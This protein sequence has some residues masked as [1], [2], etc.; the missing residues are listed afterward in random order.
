[1]NPSNI[2]AERARKGISLEKAGKAIGV[3]ANTF[4]S[5]EKG[6]KE[7]RATN[8]MKLAI[9]FDCT[10]DY[11]LGYTNDRNGSAIAYLNQ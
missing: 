9:F 4:Q 2:R 3:S 8:L 1:M 6:E 10:P 7:P 11:L 5:W